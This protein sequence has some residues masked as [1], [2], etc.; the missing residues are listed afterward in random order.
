MSNL[1]AETLYSRAREQFSI[2]SKN[3]SMSQWIEANTTLKKQP[4]SFKGYEFQRKI[5]DDMHPDLSVIKISQIGL[6]EIQIRKALAFLVRNRGTSLIFSLPTEDMFQRVSKAR[7]KPIVT[8][9]KVFNT[10]EDMLNKSTRSTEMMQFSQSWLYLVP[11]IESAATSI[12]ADFVMNDEVDLSDQQMIS[13]FNSRMQASKYKISQKFSTPTYPSFGIDSNWNISDQ[14]MYMLR[15]TCCGHWQHPEFNTKFVHIPGMPDVGNLTDIT[16]AYKDELELENAY[17]KC[18]KCHSPL[19][20]ADPSLREWVAAY[21]NRKNSRGYR[22]GC[23]SVSNLSLPYIF[24]SMWEYQKTEHIRG[25]YNTVLGTPYSDGNIQIPTDAIHACMTGDTVMPELDKINE[26]LWVGIDMGS[27]CHVTV[28]AG[29]SKDKL[30]IIAM[31]QKRSD[32]IVEHCKWLAEKTKLRGGCVDRHPYTP[33]ANEILKVTSGKIMP[34]E[35]RGTK[36]VNIKYDDYELLSHV[37]V[38]HTWFLDTIASR[39]RKRSLS[40]SGYGHQKSIVTEHFRDMVRE[41]KMDGKPAQWIKLHGNDHYL[42][43]SAFMLASL[44]VGEIVYLKSD[45]DKRILSISDI[46]TIKDNTPN[47]IGFGKSTRM[48]TPNQLGV[49]Y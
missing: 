47:L 25:F 14:H 11:A 35:Y 31:Y 20:L 3:M 4:F 44:E 10:P 41:E 17:V 28:G 42:H 38:N 45:V 39:I 24:K 9:D 34:T 16:V 27:V 30:R 13:L 2:D 12:P 26:D 40:I 46:T 7:V 29:P 36:D 33:T 8:S 19:D 15:C 1:F 37:Q 23:F 22:I 43:S 5:V 21:P 18:E 48:T 6:T 49:I 32:E